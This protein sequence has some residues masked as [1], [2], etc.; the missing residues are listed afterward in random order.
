MGCNNRIPEKYKYGSPGIGYPTDHG[1]T[2]ALRTIQANFNSLDWS[3]AVFATTLSPCVMCTRSL[4]HLHS[5]GLRRL[6]IA[7]A[8]TFQGPSNELLRNLPGMTVVELTNADGIAMMQDFAR[9]YPWDW[10]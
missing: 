5:L 2:S 1:E 9:T 4:I 8:K 10:A 3:N 7:E 6:V